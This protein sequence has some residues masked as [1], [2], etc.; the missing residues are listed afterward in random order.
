MNENGIVSPA[1][2]GES[3]LCAECAEGCARCSGLPWCI[4]YGGCAMPED[5]V[6]CAGYNPTCAKLGVCVSRFQTEWAAA[7][8][9]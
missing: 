3:A 1:E 6:G 2:N 4:C 8:G 5:E 9:L 7:S